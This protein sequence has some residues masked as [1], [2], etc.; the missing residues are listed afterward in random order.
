[1]KLLFLYIALTFTTFNSFAQSGPNEPFE[2]EIT[3]DYLEI[4]ENPVKGIILTIGKK[5]KQ[6]SG[7]GI[8]KLEITITWDELLNFFKAQKSPKGKLAI[9]FGSEAYNHNK[10]KLLNDYFV[11]EEDFKL[12]T[13]VAQEL[14][15][16]KG[17]TIKKG[18]YKVTYDSKTR[19]Y[20][21]IF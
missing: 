19:T 8:C 12:D 16:K 2:S 6:C 13:Q 4:N 15:F 1:M 14:G 3:N 21:T 18:K 17:Y 9:R 20:N 11:L 5:S 10:S 7:F